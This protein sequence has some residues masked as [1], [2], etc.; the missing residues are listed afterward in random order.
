MD[1]IDALN[2]ELSQINRRVSTILPSRSGVNDSKN[3][4][5]NSDPSNTDPILV[6]T[7]VL[8]NLRPF[9]SRGQLRA[10]SLP[11]YDGSTSLDEFL[12]TYDGLVPESE[13][14]TIKVIRSK[15]SCKGQASE[16]IRRI[17]NI[18]ECREEITIFPLA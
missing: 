16:L 13:C 11:N 4:R 5:S 3:C 14:A 7:E 10:V 6:L 17:A 18:I 15:E 1:N 8:Q 12:A 9:E 2:Y